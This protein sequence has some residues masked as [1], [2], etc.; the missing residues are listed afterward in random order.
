MKTAL[1]EGF[2]PEVVAVSYRQFLGDSIERS[3]KIL[4]LAIKM[5]TQ[6]DHLF[7]STDLDSGYPTTI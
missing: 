3:L 5:A 7:Q 2:L 6:Q 1:L 4:D